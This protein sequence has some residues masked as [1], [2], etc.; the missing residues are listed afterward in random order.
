MDLSLF[1]TDAMPLRPSALPKLMKCPMR[2]VMSYFETDEGGAAAQTGNVI[3]GVAAAFHSGATREEALEAIPSLMQKFPLAKEDYARR[4]SVAY[5]DDPANRTAVVLWVE[6]AVTLRVREDGTVPLT[7][8]PPKVPGDVVVIGTL[9]QVRR[10]ADGS[11][12]VWDI[13]TGDASTG[14]ENVDEYQRQQAAYVL[15]A[16][17][18]LDPTIQPGGL[19][20][21]PGYFEGPRARRHLPTKVT[22]RDAVAQMR[23]VALDVVN[24]RRGHRSFR[25][26]IGACGFCPFKRYPK[27]ST[28]AD[29]LLGVKS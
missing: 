10:V 18:T 26:S 16:I 24:I 22:I 2:Y 29:G 28:R 23:D 6:K 9:D 7:L 15:A 25:P 20:Y 5:L 27:C 11:L 4:H 19:I 12:Q 3:H 21:T 14:D 8:D 13:K 1:G 17:Q